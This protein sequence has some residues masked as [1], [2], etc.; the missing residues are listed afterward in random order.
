MT[1]NPVWGGDYQRGTSDDFNRGRITTHGSE[2][3][4]DQIGRCLNREMAK[5]QWKIKHLTTVINIIVMSR[6]LVSG[7]STQQVFSPWLPSK[8]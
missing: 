4:S 8:S 5:K 6:S 3:V 2:R 7:L 1:T